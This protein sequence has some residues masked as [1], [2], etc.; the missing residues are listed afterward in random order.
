MVE[1]DLKIEN[2]ET[3]STLCLEQSLK[4]F[5]SNIFRLATLLFDIVY[6]LYR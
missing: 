3:A 4:A 5:E 2:A 6:G 1:L